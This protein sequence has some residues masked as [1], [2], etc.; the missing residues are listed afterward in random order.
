MPARGAV[1]LSLRRDPLA[2]QLDPRARRALSSLV[3][4]AAARDGPSS[5]SGL[6]PAVQHPATILVRAGD[7]SEEPR[8]REGRSARAPD[9]RRGRA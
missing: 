7:G 1:Q 6:H 2:A 9:R 5:S 8:R 3:D 4:R